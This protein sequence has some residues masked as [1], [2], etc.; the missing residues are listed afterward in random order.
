M[1]RGLGWVLENRVRA[2]LLDSPPKILRAGQARG[3]RGVTL[4]DTSPTVGNPSHCYQHHISNGTTEG[5]RSMASAVTFFAAAA[6]FQPSPVTNLFC[7][8]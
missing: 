2:E 7:V 1:P 5:A 4:S 3:S 6:R 8:G